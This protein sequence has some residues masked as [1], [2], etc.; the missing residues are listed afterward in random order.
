MLGAC[1]P[2]EADEPGEPDGVEAGEEAAPSD[3]AALEKSS[4]AA[5]ADGHGCAIGCVTARGRAG[6]SGH[7]ARGGGAS[8]GRRSRAAGGGPWAPRTGKPK[9]S[10]E[11]RGHEARR[12]LARSTASGFSH[13]GDGKERPFKKKSLK[14]ALHSIANHFAAHLGTDLNVRKLDCIKMA[15][16]AVTKA[17]EANNSHRAI[18]IQ[19]G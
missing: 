9:R 4:G 5:A 16:D 10:L 2:S 7:G 13:D 12:K 8:H 14:Q 15:R 6:A 18:A 17:L 19:S 1:E 3:E 11:E